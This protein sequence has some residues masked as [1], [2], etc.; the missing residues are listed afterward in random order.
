[1]SFLIGY[2]LLAPMIIPKISKDT[3]ITNISCYSILVDKVQD[4]VFQEITFPGGK[5]QIKDGPSLSG[6]YNGQMG[7]TI[8]KFVEKKFP[9]AKKIL[10]EIDVE[11][12]ENRF[13]YFDQEDKLIIT[14][15]HK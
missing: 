13:S 1:M 15:T 11:N 3:G 4:K 10:L 12:K 2:K 5:H 8:K 14:N 7:G 6:I 9:Q